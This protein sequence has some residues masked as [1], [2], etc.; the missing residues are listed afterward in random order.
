MNREEKNKAIDDLLGQLKP[1]FNQSKEDSWQAIQDKL[2]QDETPVYS[3]MEYPK[4]KFPFAIAASIALLLSLSLFFFSRSSEKHFNTCEQNITLPDN[5]SAFL[6]KNSDLSF[7]D[8][9]NKR[10][11]HLKGGGIF[12]V[13]KGKAFILN[14]ELGDIEVLGTVFSV[15]A[16]SK[17]LIVKCSEGSVKVSN[18]KFSEVIVAGQSLRATDSEIVVSKIKINELEDREN[19]VLY[20]SETPIDEVFKQL[21]NEFDIQLESKIELGALV[22]SGNFS[23]NNLNEAL[24]LVCEPMGIKYEIKNSKVELYK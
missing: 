15:N 2:S 9:E 12:K 6:F 24:S 17:H 14:T 3:M 18:G 8:L 7:E 19:G 22:Y 10:S 20:F 13:K 11:L 16:L 5:S 23:N 4:K 1:P 21:E